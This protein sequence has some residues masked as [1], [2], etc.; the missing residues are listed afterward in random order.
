M[1]MDACCFDLTM[2]L[3]LNS[4]VDSSDLI[5][6]S[7]A[8]FAQQLSIRLSTKTGTASFPFFLTSKT[9]RKA[10]HSD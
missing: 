2:Y 3:F 6:Y 1:R 4:D 5:T 7:L 10:R 9:M 8:P